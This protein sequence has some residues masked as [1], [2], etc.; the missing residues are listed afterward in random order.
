MH[1]QVHEKNNISIWFQK[2]V[3]GVSTLITCIFFIMSFRF[4]FFSVLTGFTL[5]INQNLLGV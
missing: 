5:D 3:F 4:D 2:E 1:V